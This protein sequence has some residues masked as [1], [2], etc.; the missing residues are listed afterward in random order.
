MQDTFQWGYWVA[1]HKAQMKKIGLWLFIAIVVVIWLIFFFNLGS[2]FLGRS[3]AKIAEEDLIKLVVNFKA[4]KPPESIQIVEK[5]VLS[6]GEGRVDVFVHLKNPNEKWLV[7]KYIY[8]LSIGG[9]IT[10]PQTTFLLP[11]EDKFLIAA[12]VAS[13]TSSVEL[14]TQNIQ[15]QKIKNLETLQKLEFATEELTYSPVFYEETSGYIF[16]EVKAVVLN[17][18][19]FGFSNVQVVVLVVYNNEIIGVGQT[20]AQDW[21]S[22]EERNFSFGWPKKFPLASEL[23]LLVSTNIFDGNNLILPGE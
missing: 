4:L 16:G 5:K 19:V 9:T 12:N 6:R 3:S 1:K 18:S 21:G 10:S 20:M 7:K 2:Y 11:G 15:W 17:K 14:I 13:P 8:Q 23:K 22:G